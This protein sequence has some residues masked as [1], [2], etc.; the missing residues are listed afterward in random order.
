MSWLRTWQESGARRELAALNLRLRSA[1]DLPAPSPWLQAAV[2]QHA[3][4]IRD[5][6]T[7]TSGVLGPIEIAGY[8]NGV[9]DAA[10][11]WGWRFPTSAVKPDWV[12]IRLLAACSLAS[13]PSTAI[14]AGLPT[15]P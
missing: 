13:Q 4:A 10:A 7:L 14:A 6:L 2:D 15:N 5:I 3:A 1:L 9:L 8:A 11:D 12:I